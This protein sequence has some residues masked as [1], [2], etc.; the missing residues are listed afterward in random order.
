MW[1]SNYK[2]LLGKI[3]L[4]E[5]EIPFEIIHHPDFGR[6]QFLTQVEKTLPSQNIFLYLFLILSSIK[7]IWGTDLL[8]NS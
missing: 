3:W 6:R 7:I 5:S 2:L 1:V 4:S 8:A